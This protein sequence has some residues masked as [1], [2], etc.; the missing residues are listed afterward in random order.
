MSYDTHLLEIKRHHH[1]LNISL[2][3]GVSL[4]PQILSKEKEKP[5]KLAAYEMSSPL[6]KIW[7]T[8]YVQKNKKSL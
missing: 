4:R 6:L 1:I 3:V 2:H 8:L 7:E 5:W